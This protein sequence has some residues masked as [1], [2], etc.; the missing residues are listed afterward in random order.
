MVEGGWVDGGR[1]GGVARDEDGE[2]EF[3]RERCFRDG[4]TRCELEKELFGFFFPFFRF[5]KGWGTQICGVIRIE[6]RLRALFGRPCRFE[7]RLRAAVVSAA[8]GFEE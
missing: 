2:L 3:E 1:S 7:A 4:R 5:A 8:G 6:A